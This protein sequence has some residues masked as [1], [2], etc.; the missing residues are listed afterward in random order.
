VATLPDDT[1]GVPGGDI[2]SAHATGLPPSW[3]L[4]D[5]RR[6]VLIRLKRIYTF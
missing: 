1:F 4:E 5:Q 6:W 2:R 3:R